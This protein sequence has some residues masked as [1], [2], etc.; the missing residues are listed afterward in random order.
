MVDERNKVTTRIPVAEMAKANLESLFPQLTAEQCEQL[1]AGKPLTLDGDAVNAEMYKR[2]QQCEDLL[3]TRTKRLLLSE[4]MYSHYCQ[5]RDPVTAIMVF[6]DN[7]RIRRACR[8]VD[9]F[10]AQ[11]YPLKQLIIVNA[12]TQN[13]TNVAH[14][15]VLELKYPP[16]KPTTLGDMRNF[17]LERLN[18]E[19]VM[20]FWDDD[21]IYD[22]DL[23]R[24]MITCRNPSQAACMLRVQPRIDIVNAVIGICEEPEGITNTLLA[25]IARD[26]EKPIRFE[27]QTGGEDSLFVKTFFKFK[28]HVIDN[29]TYPATLLKAVVFDGNN[30]A[31]RQDFMGVYADPDKQGQL[32]LP[33]EELFAM[34]QTLQTFGLQLRANPNTKLVG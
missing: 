10:V 21:D 15:D 22:P 8:A 14:P 2:L 32:F 29:R 19:F 1:R 9:Q 17:A 33:P 16:D 30:V 24:Y 6:G 26:A 13:V 20:P 31:T 3:H 12:T 4:M 23:I 27:P 34:R 11:T 5:P 18:S 7:R 25:R 28:T